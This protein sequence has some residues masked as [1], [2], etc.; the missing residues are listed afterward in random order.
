[1]VGDRKVDTIYPLKGGGRKAI[2]ISIITA[3]QHFPPP[4]LSMVWIG[5]PVVG[6]LCL[7]FC[8]VVVCVGLSLG[9]SESVMSMSCLC[10]IEEEVG[11]NWKQLDHPLE[12]LDHRLGQPSSRNEIATPNSTCRYV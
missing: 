5:T 9:R 2:Y 6:C 7:C 8:V 12:Q 4:R 3:Y 11:L 1:M 10:V